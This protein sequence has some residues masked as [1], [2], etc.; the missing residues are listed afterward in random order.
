MSRYSFII[1]YN[2]QPFSGWQ[3][4]PDAITVEGEL[5]KAFTKILQQPIDLIGQGRTDAGV[6]ARGQV[7][8]VD[9]PDDVDM[10]KLIHGVN[11]LAGSDV[12]IKHYEKVNDD[13][14]ARFD[15]L[16]RSYSYRVVKYPSP[17]LNAISWY[18]GELKEFGLLNDCA[19]LLLGEHDFDGFSK[20]NEE[21]FT[22]LCTVEK[23]QWTETETAFV[24]EISANRFLRNMVRRLVGT[25]AEV[26]QGKY[27]VQDVK[28]IL[29]RREGA[30]ASKTAPAKG[31]I[32][33]KVSYKKGDY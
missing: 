9:L 31:L 19:E 2:G 17:L 1:E 22:T 21:N 4:Q 25:M 12:F 7:A 32:L 29:D 18:P 16:T 33:E 6:H 20:Y 15:A 8:H 10:Y 13:F 27:A 3:I 14:H 30:K 26:A 5:E 11:S 28:N 24:F 23:A